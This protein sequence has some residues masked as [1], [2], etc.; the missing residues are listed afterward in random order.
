[1]MIAAPSVPVVGCEIESSP[2]YIR[3]LPIVVLFPHNRC[4]CRCVMCDIWRIRETREITHSD[5][6]PHL[7]S[8]RKLGVRWVVLSGGEPLMHSDLRS[9]TGLLKAEGI[10]VTLL[11]A[12]LLLEGLAREVAE[13]VDDVIVSLD[14]P[15]AVHDR[16][17]NVPRAFDRLARGVLALRSIRPQIEI[18]ARSTIQKENHTCLRQTVTVAK[19]LEL[20]SI[21]LLGVDLT[22]TAFNRPEGWPLERQANVGLD[23]SEVR[24]LEREIEALICEHA[25]DIASCFVVESPDKLRR[26]VHHFRAQL[27]EEAPVAPSCNAPWVSTVIEAD[28]TVR[29]CFFHRAIGNIHLAPIE[30]IVNSSQALEFRRRLDVS[31]NP[32][33]QHC[34]CSLSRR[35]K[36]TSISFERE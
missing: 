28:G 25:G 34:V 2:H 33:C 20:N 18:R 8:F 9:L 15:P 16:V 14:G 31:S 21:S 7:D 3:S 19:Q 1:M 10:R 5:L 32:I 12:G 29:P 36:P 23:A 30:Q 13:I 17:R 26:I 24:A 4:N 22:S 6:A 35:E 27:G 11:T